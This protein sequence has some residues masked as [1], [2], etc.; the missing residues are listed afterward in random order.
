MSLRDSTKLIEKQIFDAGN[1][2]VKTT[3]LF[4]GQSLPRYDRLIGRPTIHS[5]IRLLFARLAST[6]SNRVFAPDR[7]S[8]SRRYWIP[9]S[10]QKKNLRC[11]TELAGTTSWICAASSQSCRWSAF[12]ARHRNSFGKKSGH[13]FWRT[14]LSEPSW[15][16]LQ[17]NTS[18]FHARSVSRER[19][20]H[21][22]RS[23]PC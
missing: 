16:R 5:P 14:T 15:R 22:R 6:S 1:A 4:A 7:L 21:S 18:C 2:L 11:C 20:K 8:L 10:T 23:N 12:D 9:S 19:C 3:T 17:A 13:T